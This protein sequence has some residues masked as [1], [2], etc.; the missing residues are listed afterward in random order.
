MR[1]PMNAIIGISGIELENENHP[2]DVLDSF[3]RINNSG[4]TL[5]GI[6][7]DIL[8]LSKVETGKLEIV[9]DK[10]D[11]ASLINDTVLL[12]VM[13]I[14]N[15]NI[16]VIVKAN[17]NLPTM[18]KG[19]DLRIKQIL[20]N[21][22]SNSIKYTDE[23]QVLLNIDFQINENYVDLIF[24]VKDTGR[25]MTGE[26][27]AVMYDEYT[28][29]GDETNRMTEG[30]GLGMNITKRLVEM[31]NGKIEAE[32]EPN[33]GSTFIVYLPQEPVDISPIGKELAE[34]LNDFKLLSRRDKITLIR[35]HMPDFNVL[36]VDDV[37][38]NLFVAKG[39]M[40]P[41]GAHIDTAAS[42]YEALEKIRTGSIYDIIFMDHMMPGMDGIETTKLIREEGCKYPIIALTANAIADK[43]DV[44]FE[45]GFDDFLP[46]PFDIKQLDNILKKY[47][48]NRQNKTSYL[49]SRLKEIPGLEVDSALNIIGGMEKIYIDTV[50]ITTR[51]MP[52]RIKN[53]DKSVTRDPDAFKLEVHG[54][55]SILANIG[56]HNLSICAAQLERAAIDLDVS[57]I[58]E[59]YQPFR[60]GLIELFEALNEVL[61]LGFT[62]IE[63]TG[64]KSLLPKI[65]FDVKKAT[66]DF[67][68]L[69][70]LEILSPYI[71]VSYNL[72][73]DKLLKELVFS[74]EA[75]DYESALES[76]AA[77]EDLKNG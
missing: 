59:N 48:K 77:M 28:M 24:T 42:G 49:I 31:M 62:G 47:S 7:N 29:F 26:Q 34:R 8:D 4:R 43:K 60:I 70:A 11:V 40:K 68:S 10:Y 46:K 25:G 45:N 61:Q 76:I 36:I 69:L 66:Q 39:L 38:E 17:E 33:T 30:T 35:E 32:S 23:G 74:L 13:L 41:Y 22:L 75:S 50:K 63:K 12:N 54:T 1:T 64:D 51:M 65:I 37:D 72:E 58:N 56:A 2:P 73:T 18:L 67:D 16:K 15:K 27:L 3:G 44:Y 14:G 53:I 20:N 21:L 57:Y 6:I 19:D 71:G 55:K 5:L 9:P 52:E